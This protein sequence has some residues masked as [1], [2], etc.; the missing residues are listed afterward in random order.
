MFLN[1]LLEMLFLK[2]TCFSK[3]IV[4]TAFQE[5]YL[6]TVKFIVVERKGF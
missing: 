3:H 4:Q 1:L 5:I 6:R 2:K